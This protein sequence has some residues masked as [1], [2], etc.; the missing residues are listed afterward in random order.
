[1]LAHPGQSA[2]LRGEVT[3]TYRTYYGRAPSNAQL[4]RI[5]WMADNGAFADYGQFRAA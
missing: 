5:L 3:S 1:M 2:D 4:D